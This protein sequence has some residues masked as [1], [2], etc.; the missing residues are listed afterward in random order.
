[1]NQTSQDRQIKTHSPFLHK[2]RPS[3][4]SPLQILPTQCNPCIPRRPPIH[5]LRALNPKPPHRTF[6]RARTELNSWRIVH[7][8]RRAC[9]GLP[10]PSVHL[11]FI[12]PPAAVDAHPNAG[13]GETG[14]ASAGR[15]MVDLMAARHNEAQLKQQQKRRR[16]QQMKDDGSWVDEPDVGGIAGL[17]EGYVKGL[18][19]DLDIQ[20]TSVG[21][22]GGAGGRSTPSVFAFLVGGG[23]ELLP[24]APEPGAEAAA[25]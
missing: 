18:L 13:S 12:P 1:C 3:A 8:G 22:S 4:I 2:R 7:V 10:F 19:E 14:A 25:A 9:W 15:Q 5:P 11:S 21:G 6:G 20:D 17:D 24:G 23:G 16:E